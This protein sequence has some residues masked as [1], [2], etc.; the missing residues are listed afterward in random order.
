MFQ[1]TYTNVSQECTSTP[2]L[3]QFKWHH[4]AGLKATDSASI[5][6]GMTCLYLYFLF[7]KAFLVFKGDVPE[8]IPLHGLEEE[9]NF[10]LHGT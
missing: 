3:I 2:S 4:Q 10:K 9:K 7:F 5:P 1:G 6:L 8:V